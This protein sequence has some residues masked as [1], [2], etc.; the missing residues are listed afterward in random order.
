MAVAVDPLLMD[1]TNAGKLLTAD[2]TNN[3]VLFSI[4][5][6]IWGTSGYNPADVTE[7]LPLLGT[8][9]ALTTQVARTGIANVEIVTVAVPKGQEIVFATIGRNDLDAD[10]GLG[11]AALIAEVTDAGTSGRSIGDQVFFAH[12]HFARVPMHLHQRLALEWPIDYTAP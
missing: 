10:Y 1:V 6:V 5:A 11:E 2:A 7:V 3:A 8:S 4:V 9:T 12:A